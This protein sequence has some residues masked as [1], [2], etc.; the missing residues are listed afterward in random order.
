MHGETRSTAEAIVETA[1]LAVAVLLTRFIVGAVGLLLPPV[2]VLGDPM[3]F[4]AAWPRPALSDY[5]HSGLRDWMV[6]SLWAIGAGLA[7]YVSPRRSPLDF[8]LS[9][10]AGV[11]AVLVALVPTNV[12]GRP[13]DAAA[14][15]HAVAAV[16]MMTLLA[17]MSFRFAGQTGAE[18]DDQDEAQHRR[19]RR[20]HL[21]CA[22]GILASLG[23]TLVCLAVD[24]LPNYAALIGESG[25]VLAFALSWLVM[26][27][28]LTVLA[29]RYAAGWRVRHH[30]RRGAL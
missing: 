7:V 16:A 27:A 13:V 10:G 22:V 20:F 25:A 26:S 11:C 5:Y 2:L 30:V 12:V 1:D 6:G 28:R 23:F 24:L 8:G 4:G 19:R 21:G 15:V 17:A 14:V 9:L 29:R 18:R 3:L